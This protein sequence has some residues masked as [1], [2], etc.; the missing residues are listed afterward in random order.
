[1]WVQTCDGGEEL[2]ESVEVELVWE[3]LGNDWSV[4]AK[5][6]HSYPWSSKAYLLEDIPAQARLDTARSARE[7]DL[8]SSCNCPNLPAGSGGPS[9]FLPKAAV[10]VAPWYAA[11]ALLNGP[12]AAGAPTACSSLRNW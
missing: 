2:I 8:R 12:G 4:L 1:M 5:F 6:S 9:C 10:P 11:H 3:D 7:V